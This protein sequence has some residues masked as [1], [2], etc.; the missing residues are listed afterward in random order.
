M[1][2][3]CVKCLLVDTCVQGYDKHVGALLCTPHYF[4]FN[5]DTIMGPV[6]SCAYVCAMANLAAC[7]LTQGRVEDP[8]CA[9]LVS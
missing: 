6:R 5:A 2:D 4:S 8:L 1:K 3:D 9:E 7:L